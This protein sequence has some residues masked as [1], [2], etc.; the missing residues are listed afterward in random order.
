MKT[1]LRP[2]TIFSGLWFMGCAG[3]TSWAIL[4]LS[5]EKSLNKLIGGAS[6]VAL[7]LCVS[8]GGALSGALVGPRLLK[9]GGWSRMGFGGAGI[10]LLSLI[11]GV[12]GFSIYATV[13]GAVAAIG[14]NSPP[15][16]PWY[17]LLA[18]PFILFGLSCVYGVATMF[19]V[20]W[21]LPAILLAGSVAGMLHPF[22][23]EI[24]A[25]AFSQDP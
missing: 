10:A 19:V 11:A 20:W 21:L 2:R 23:V 14:A 4:N 9:L 7:I 22:F 3:L 25:A 17:E 5:D 12:A 24:A 1:L 16:G 8:L 18:A 15:R 6:P 13:G